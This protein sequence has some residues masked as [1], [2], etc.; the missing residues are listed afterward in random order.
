M[1]KAADM[2]KDEE[3]NSD[4]QDKSA[5]TL[6]KSLKDHNTSQNLSHVIIQTP[7]MMIQNDPDLSFKL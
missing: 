7:R 4:F 3:N 1:I 2:T 5:H 6:Q